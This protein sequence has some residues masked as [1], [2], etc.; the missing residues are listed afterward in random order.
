MLPNLGGVGEG[1]SVWKR[2][3]SQI[4]L[5]EKVVCLEEILVLVP[6]LFPCGLRTR[7]GTVGPS[8]E[9]F[10]EFQWLLRNVDNY[11]LAF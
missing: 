8:S 9:F 4:V 3:V 7:C 10:P 6:I 11:L 1:N 2:E 5:F